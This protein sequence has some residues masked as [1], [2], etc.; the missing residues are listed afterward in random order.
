MFSWKA[1]DDQLKQDALAGAAAAEYGQSF[2]A[3]Y[4]QTFRT[5]VFGL[6]IGTIGCFQG[7]STKLHLIAFFPRPAFRQSAGGSRYLRELECTTSS[8]SGFVGA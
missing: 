1:A 3:R 8:G 5:T 4:R 6:I 7:M 2:A